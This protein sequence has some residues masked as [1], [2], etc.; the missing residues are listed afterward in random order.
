[1]ALNAAR[2]IRLGPEPIRIS[3]IEAY[4]RLMGLDDADERE[5]L[6]VLVQ[7][8]D[9]AYLAWRVQ[10]PAGQCAD[11]TGRPQARRPGL[12]TNER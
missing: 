10:R 1:M 12:R 9:R 8:M 6:V 3:E 4:A 11:R 5:E 7:A 2:S